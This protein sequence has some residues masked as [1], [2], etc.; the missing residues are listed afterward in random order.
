MTAAELAP[1]RRNSPLAARSWLLEARARKASSPTEAV[2]LIRDHYTDLPQPETDVTLADCYQAA[3]D[4]KH[5]AEF[6][7]RVY[8]HYL[9]GAAAA[10]A[11]AA[12]LTLKD[13]LGADFPPP[14][15]PKGCIAPTACWTPG[16]TRRHARNTKP[17]PPIGG[18][19]A[20]SANSPWC[21]WA[22]PTTWPGRCRGRALS[23]RRSQPPTPSP[24]P[25]ACTTSPNARAAG[26]TTRR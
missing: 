6:Y 11:A 18:R 24:P 15:P 13:S 19:D 21:A 12:L 7:Q 10:R 22:P 5:A 25:N 14:P 23:A 9:T 17:S 26:A 1:A 16:S 2:R 3:N 20:A 8:Y 4:L